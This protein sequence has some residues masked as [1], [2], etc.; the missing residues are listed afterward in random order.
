VSRRRQRGQALVEAALVMLA[1]V[2]MVVGLL[3]VALPFQGACGRGPLELEAAAS[4]VPC[5]GIDQADGAC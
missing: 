1:I 4:A 2:P 5:S 3:G